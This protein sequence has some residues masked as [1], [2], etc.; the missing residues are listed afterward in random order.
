MDELN[1][2]S[3][4]AVSNDVLAA[5]VA[6]IAERRP[7]VL[8]TVVATEQSVPRGP[9]SKMLIH[10]N[11]ATV[12]TIGGGEMEARVI[13]EAS[14]ALESGQP[15]QLAYSLLDAAAG[16]PGVCGGAV[17]I[18]LEPHMPQTTVYVIG[19]GHVGRA[20]AEL[21][22]W[23]GFRVTA[24]DDRSELAAG[25]VAEVEVQSGPFEAAL[26]LF[27][28]DAQTL[29]VMTTRNVQLDVQI[30]PVLLASEAPFIGLMGSTR[31]WEI[32]RQKLTEAGHVAADLDRVRSPIGID[33]NAE[34]PAEI[35]V[36]ILA[37]IVEHQRNAS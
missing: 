21:A 35:A 31:R 19:V 4:G 20:V 30:L 36:S 14:L 1:P 24:W 29:V 17:E 10:A 13:H 9:G 8:A 27:P 7:A 2:L 15:R 12:G 23:L 34:T 28:I 16:D 37:E 25:S 22:R 11:G 18:F 33:I 32:T 5:L 3:S 6:T 26:D